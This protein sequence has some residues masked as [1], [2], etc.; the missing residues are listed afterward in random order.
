LT[1]QR[2]GTRVRDMKEIGIHYMKLKVI[3]KM[4]ITKMYLSW[5]ALSQRQTLRK[6]K[7]KIK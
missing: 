4:L 1:G 7:N 3:N 5:R 2:E 6:Q